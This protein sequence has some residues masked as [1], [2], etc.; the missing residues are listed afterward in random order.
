M[1]SVSLGIVLIK[2]SSVQQ[3]GRIS[4]VSPGAAVEVNKKEALKYILAKHGVRENRCL[5]TN[6]SCHLRFNGFSAL[7]E[8][9]EYSAAPLHFFTDFRWSPD[10]K[11]SSIGPGRVSIPRDVDA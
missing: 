4:P 11:N 6:D 1:W 5:F 7:S 3:Y 2:A 9:I 10:S 8:D